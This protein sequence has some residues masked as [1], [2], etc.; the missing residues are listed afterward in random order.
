MKFKNF[1]LHFSE[2]EHLRISYD[3]CEDEREFLTKRR[4]V[5]FEK[6]SAMFDDETKPKTVN[7]VEFIISKVGNESLEFFLNVGVSK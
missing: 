6:M 3:L 4:D 7:E 5:I 2:S 1:S